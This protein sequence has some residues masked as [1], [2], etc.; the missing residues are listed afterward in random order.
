VGN[1]KASLEK[2]EE[3]EMAI[4]ANYQNES[5]VMEGRPLDWIMTM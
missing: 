1:R 4:N 2:E 3:E 5:Q